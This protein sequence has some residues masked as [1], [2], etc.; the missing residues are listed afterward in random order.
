MHG[1]LEANMKNQIHGNLWLKLLT[2]APEVT[3]Q[4]T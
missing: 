4:P 2:G 1:T 3:W